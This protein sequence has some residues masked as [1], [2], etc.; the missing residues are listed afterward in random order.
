MVIGTKVKPLPNDK[1][2]DWSKLKASADDKLKMAKM[3]KPLFD[4]VENIVGKG[5]N[6]GYQ[7]FFLSLNVFQKPFSSESKKVGQLVVLGF[8]ATSTAMVISWRSVTH[9]C[10]LAFSHQY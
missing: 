7:Q 10:F 2:S 9:M 1:I 3:T 8:N 6:A 5:G 4:R